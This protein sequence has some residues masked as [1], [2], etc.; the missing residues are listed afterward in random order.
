VITCEY[1]L[2]EIERDPDEVFNHDCP[3]LAA[4]VEARTV[5]YEERGVTEFPELGVE[6]DTRRAWKMRGAPL[7]EV[8]R[9]MRRLLDS[10]PTADRASLI[11]AT[12]RLLREK[13]PPP[14]D[15]TEFKVVA[16]EGGVIEISRMV[17][18]PIVIYGDPGPSQ[19]AKDWEA[20]DVTPSGRIFHEHA[21][22]PINVLQ[23][24]VRFC[25]MHIVAE[26]GNV[27]DADIAWC[28]AEGKMSDDPSKKGGP[29]CATCREFGELLL[30]VAEGERRRL[31]GFEEDEDDT[32]RMLFEDLGPPKEKP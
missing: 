8:R 25:C 6:E 20:F 2:A 1:C 16:R 26:D 17:L 15:P 22:R 30:Q 24:K 13:F 27:S 10:M 14:A 21:R 29:A 7:L 28:L 31:L 18:P 5:A 9:E 3:E 12:Q 11:D 32:P 19:G 23:D 4:A